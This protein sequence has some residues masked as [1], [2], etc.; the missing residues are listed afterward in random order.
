MIYLHR[1][2]ISLKVDIDSF[3][4]GIY[5]KKN[6]IIMCLKPLFPRIRYFMLIPVKMWSMR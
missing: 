2:F 5:K 3:K 1:P 6:L 4:A